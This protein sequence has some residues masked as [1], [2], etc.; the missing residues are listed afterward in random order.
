[1]APHAALD[2]ILI[3]ASKQSQLPIKEKSNITIALELEA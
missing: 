1:M 3:E 2:L